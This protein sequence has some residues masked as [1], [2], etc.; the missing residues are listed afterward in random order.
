MAIALGA[1]GAPTSQ[2]P[3]VRPPARCPRWFPALTNAPGAAGAP[4]ADPGA[5]GAV[6]PVGLGADKRS[7]G[8]GG[9]G[10]PSRIKKN[11]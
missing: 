11:M 1:A 9:T 6:P 5:P 8:S 2:P 10:P 4:D 3:P 7:G